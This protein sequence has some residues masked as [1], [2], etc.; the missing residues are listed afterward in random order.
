MALASVKIC[1]AGLT[2]KVNQDRA[3]NFV[4][5]DCGLFLVADGM[6]GHFAGERASQKLANAYSEWWAQISGSVALIPFSE[7]TEQLKTVLCS[8]NEEIYQSTPKGQIC[9]STIVLLFLQQDKFLL[10]TVG[11]SRCYQVSPG[12]VPRVRQISHDDVSTEAGNIGKLTRAVGSSAECGFLLQTGRVSSKTVF[13]L[14]SDGTYKFCPEAVL[15]R[16]L[17]IACVAGALQKAANWISSCVQDK[18]A[19][20]NYS[21]VLVQT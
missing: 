12:L 7:I 11:D 20:D 19:E 18:G 8:C 16:Y 21:L 5:C 13:A 1:S 10:L 4:N 3:V 6:G 17:K 9:G 14:C 15:K 2:R